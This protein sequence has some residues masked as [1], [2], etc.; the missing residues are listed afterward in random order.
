MFT[1]GYL[2]KTDSTSRSS[3]SHE[4]PEKNGNTKPILKSSIFQMYSE[5]PFLS[6]LLIGVVRKIRSY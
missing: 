1:E 6:E 5:E 2:Q 3:T 4:L